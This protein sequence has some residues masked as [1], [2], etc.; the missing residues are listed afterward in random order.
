M[1][2]RREMLNGVLSLAATPAL[3]L[4]SA[5]YQA[6]GQPATLPQLSAALTAARSDFQATRYSALDTRLSRLC[7]TAAAT[8]DASSGHTRDRASA[9]LARTYCLV[10]ELA[11]KQAKAGT[12]WVASD[13]A[14]SFAHASGDPVAIAEAATRL[15]V[16]MRQDEQFPEATNLLASTALTLQADLHDHRA[17]SAYGS[18]LLVAAYTEAQAGHRA[19]ALELLREAEDAAHRLREPVTD[20]SA[21]QCQLYRISSHTALGDAVALDYAKRLNAAA[22]PTTERKSRYWTDAAR[23]WN[24]I[25]NPAQTLTALE[26]AEAVS[27]EDVRR[28]SMQ[29]LAIALMKDSPNLVGLAAFATRIGVE[30]P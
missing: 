6:T 10:S 9:I 3:G 14:L 19:N 30:R 21:V 28:P 4:H 27:V 7:A 22:L 18:V 20:F 13:R 11:T 16:A 29:K 1:L 23:A 25:G 26:A 5:L 12:A 17:L 2:R 8:R 24:M 15:S